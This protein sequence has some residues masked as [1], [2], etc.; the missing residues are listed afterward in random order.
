MRTNLTHCILAGLGL[1][2][3]SQ[4]QA[5]TVTG[6]ITST[7]TLISACQVNGSSAS[8]GLNFGALDFGTQDALFGTANAQVLGGSG[9]AMSILCSAGTIPA[10][11]VRAGTNDGQSSGG[12]RALA[13]GAGNFVPYDFY[14][15]TGRT[16]VLDI[17]GTITL[18]T[19]TG[20]AQTVNLYGQARG[21]AGLP[22]GVYTDTVAVELTF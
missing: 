2:L 19:S 7:L 22:A 3:A 9:G 11:R 16:Q 21:K 5:A 4:A 6:N 10:I 14:T 13:D 8:S 15:D 12:T 1:A 17:D 20:V 18:P